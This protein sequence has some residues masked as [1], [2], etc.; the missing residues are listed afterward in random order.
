[1]SAS[2]KKM[3]TFA[4]TSQQWTYD[5]TDSKPTEESTEDLQTKG[6]D[7]PNEYSIFVGKV[8]VG[9]LHNEFVDTEGIRS[10]FGHEYVN[11]LGPHLVQD[12][13]H[14][15][16]HLYASGKLALYY[17]TYKL[18]RGYIGRLLILLNLIHVLNLENKLNGM[19]QNAK[20]VEWCRAHGVV[21]QPP[22]HPEASSSDSCDSLYSSDSEEDSNI[23]DLERRFRNLLNTQ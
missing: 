21:Y 15:V 10:V 14:L 5:T 11:A 2:I 23:D 22:D 13:Q 1:M 6:N 4:S 3:L 19:V 17:N 12:V 8:V 16:D 9:Y 7:G 18:H 20:K